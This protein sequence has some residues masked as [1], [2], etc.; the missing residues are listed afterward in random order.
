MKQVLRDLLAGRRKKIVPP[1]SAHSWGKDINFVQSHRRGSLQAS[2]F[3]DADIVIGTWWETMEWIKDLPA[4]KGAKTHF[5]QGH[6]VFDGL[7][8]DRV[9]AVYR[10]DCPK[11]TVSAWLSD[12]LRDEYQAE[13]IAVIPNGVELDRFKAMAG[14]RNP[15]EAG[16][17]WSHLPQKNSMMAIEACELAR[18]RLPQLH[19]TV[20]GGGASPQPCKDRD[21]ITYLPAPPQSEIP[22]IYARCSLWLF[23]SIAEGFGLPI[24]E[25]L[26]CGTPVV[27]TPAGAAPLLINDSNGR[28]IDCTAAAMADAIVD[29]LGLPQDDYQALSNRASKTAMQYD[30]KDSARRFESALQ[31]IVDT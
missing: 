31:A 19:L 10:I 1:A 13:V 25:A 16:F 24:L 8:I 28:L 14:Q 23:S 6:E 26:A 4:G 7:P 18:A 3:P 15:L 9:K 22:S 29:I 17:V 2:D 30:W 12:I 27:A 20:F 5:V 11:I 21:W